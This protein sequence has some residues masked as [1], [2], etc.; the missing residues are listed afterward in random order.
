[1]AL[2]IPLLHPS[3]NVH[4][5]VTS[6]SIRKMITSGNLKS[7]LLTFWDL[8]YQFTLNSSGLP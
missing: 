8:N 7:V 4:V 3:D 5:L 6:H 1:M 2:R